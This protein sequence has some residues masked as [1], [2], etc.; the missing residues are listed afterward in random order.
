MTNKTVMVPVELAENLDQIK[1]ARNMAMNIAAYGDQHG[2][3][4]HVAQLLDWLVS[5]IEA[6]PK[7]E[8]EPVAYMYQ[9]ED[10]GEIGF[11]DQQQLEWDFEKN[12]PRLQVIGP[13]YAAP[14]QAKA[15][16]IKSSERMP[17]KKDADGYDE[18]F[19]YDSLFNLCVRGLFYYGEFAEQKR[20][21]HWTP[22]GTQRPKPPE[23]PE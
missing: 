15:G 22:T 8:D 13:L 12:N 20:Y 19:W 16:W 21:T 3:A 7:V 9:H 4:G 18:V 5:A 17:T 6:A 14:Q 10:T 2:E 1:E 23:K 11:V